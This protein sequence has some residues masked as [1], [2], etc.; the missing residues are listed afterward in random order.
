MS[1]STPAPPQRFTSASLLLK[2]IP[3]QRT[4]EIKIKDLKPWIRGFDLKCIILQHQVELHSFLVADETALCTLVIWEN[5]QYFKSGDIVQINQGET[6]IHEDT[7]ELTVNS[8]FG[9]IKVVDWDVLTYVENEFP[10]LSSF[11]WVQTDNKYVINFQPIVEPQSQPL[12]IEYGQQEMSQSSTTISEIKQEE[13]SKIKIKEEEEEMIDSMRG[14]SRNQDN[15]RGGSGGQQQSQQS[16]HREREWE[17][18]R[19]H[20]DLDRPEEGELVDIDFASWM[21]KSDA[22]KQTRFE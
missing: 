20:T 1:S 22:K 7:F 14:G 19:P 15:R 13:D 17:Y 16:R 8:N 3:L 2:P 9:K 5:G 10:N 11:L 4:G 21:N 12:K 6:R 18:G